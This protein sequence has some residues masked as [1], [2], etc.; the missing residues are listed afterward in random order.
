MSFNP[1]L[2]PIQ[3]DADT[4]R[5]TVLTNIVKMLTYRK[6]LNDDDLESNINA[7]ISIQADDGIYKIKLSNDLSKLSFYNKHIPLIAL[8][9]EKKSKNDTTFDGNTVVVKLLPH[10]RL[11]GVNKTPIV[12]EFMTNYNKFHKILVVEY[13]SEKTKA[14][15]DDELYTEVFIEPFFMINLV[16]HVS[17]PQYEI[18]SDEESKELFESYHASKRKLQK[19]ND[20]D[21]A[22]RYLYVKKG[23]IVRIIRDNEITGKSAIYKIICHKG[24]TKA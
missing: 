14:Q 1:L 12:A 7:V 22:S 24:I 6:W 11:M 18:L 15:L 21:Q 4:T 3:K 13:V 5:K 17:S 8:E 20:T 19:M 9:T 2:L 10:Q 16:E 23:Q